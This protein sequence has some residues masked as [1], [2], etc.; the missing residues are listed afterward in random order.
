VHGVQHVN[1]LAADQRLTLRRVGLTIIYG[2]NGSG[3]SGY[4]RI[5]KKAC[6]A[7]VPSHVDEIIPDIYD[8]APGTPSATIEYAISG[9]NRN[10]AWRLGQAADTALSA[11]SV[12]DCRTTIVHVDETNDVA[13]T[14]FPLK[15]L[16]ALAQLG[17]SIKDELASEITQL[18]VHTPQI[19]RM[20]ACSPATAVGRLMAHL[21]ADT[22]PVAVERLASLTRPE[23]DRLAQ[24][25]ADFSG[26]PA[27]AA[28]QLTA[29]KGKVEKHIS[30]L[31]RLFASIT[32]GAA[33]DLRRLSDESDTAR[34]VA[35][36]ASSVL[37]RD[38][39]LPQI[40]SG[41]VGERADL[42]RGGSLCRPAL[43][44]HQSRKRLRA[45]PAGTDTSSC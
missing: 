14:P 18:K 34:R 16:G 41:V 26:D 15:L 6:R 30:R 39:P 3:K 9:Q 19:I 20:P 43:P 44:G 31:D 17:K 7:R 11:V 40:G 13:Y 5:L 36:A 2:D 21:A 8:P 35:G 25:T 45:L 10:C 38:Q 33:E 24:L 22:D 32:D 42:L 1:A 37:F 29:L 23:Q 28:R 4:A 12:F 27:R